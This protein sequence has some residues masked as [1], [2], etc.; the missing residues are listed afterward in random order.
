M[1]PPEISRLLTDWH[2]AG[3]TGSITLHFKDGA[4]LKAD[5]T[6]SIRIARETQVS[7]ASA[8]AGGSDGKTP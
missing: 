5:S 2:N 4:I 6:I 1:I 3:Q 8:T 7:H